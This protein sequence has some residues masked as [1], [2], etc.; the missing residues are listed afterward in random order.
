[1]MTAR[2]ILDELNQ[3]DERRRLEAK[4]CASGK[5]GKSF[6]ETVCAFANEPNMQGGHLLLGVSNDNSDLFETYTVCG[7]ENP[8]Q[9]QQDI[10]NGCATHFNQKIRP[11]IEVETLNGKT[12]IVVYVPEAERSHKPVY[13]SNQ[14][15]PQAARR[16][17]GSTDVKCTEDDLQVFYADRTGESFDRRIMEDAAMDDLDPDEIEHYRALRRKVNPAAEELAWSDEELLESLSAIRMVNGNYRPTL[18]G[19]LLF[20][21]RAAQRRLLPVERVDYIRVA[22]SQW[23]ED[24]DKRFE[25]TVDMRGPLLRL[26]DRALAAVVDDLPKGFRLHPGQV[27]AETPM[28]PSNALREAIINAVMHRSYREHQPIQI[29]RYQ[30]RIEIHNAGFSLKPEEELGQPRSELRNPHLAAV[31]H[32]TNTAETKG[33]GI[34]VMRRLMR[35]AGFSPPTFHSDREKNTFTSRFLLAHFLNESDLTWLKS[36]STDF[37]ENQKIALI[38]LREQGAIDNTALRQL[39]DCDTL[40][41]SSELRKLRDLGFLVKMGGGARTYYVPGSK[42]VQTSQSGAEVDTLSGEVHT[43]SGEVHTL[44]DEVDTFAEE[45]LPSELRSQLATL[46]K[47]PGDKVRPLILALCQW[48]A[49]SSEEL[50]RILSRNQTSLIREHLRPLVHEKKLRLKHEDMI[51]HPAQ[52]YLTT[53]LGASSLEPSDT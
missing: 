50:S 40:S 53:E 12:V 37:T 44:G 49:L 29:I 38:F 48:R 34:R 11:E 10:A 30:N 52:A 20:G 1:M 16:R 27:Q 8:D 45:A 46:G 9:L 47:R 35:E 3:S 7:V 24:P 19:I 36:M 26:V 6:F 32:E 39:T 14:A 17:I 25:R 41:A 21:T 23:I 31:F 4:A 13:F 33:S 5:L 42:F 28:L 2:E 15:L 18:T 22:G 43:L 51:N